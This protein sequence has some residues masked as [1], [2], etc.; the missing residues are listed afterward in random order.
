MQAILAN[1]DNAKIDWRCSLP[2]QSPQ[3]FMDFS[4]ETYNAGQRIDCFVFFSRI[5]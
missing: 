2:N 5:I 1:Q 4:D 3:F